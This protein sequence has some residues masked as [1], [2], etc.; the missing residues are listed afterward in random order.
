MESERSILAVLTLFVSVYPL[1]HRLA[2]L[3]G[4]GQVDFD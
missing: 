2:E 1:V 4:F 3:W